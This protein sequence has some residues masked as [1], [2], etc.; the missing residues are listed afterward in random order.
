MLPLPIAP[1][2]RPA[3]PG[4]ILKEGLFSGADAPKQGQIAWRLGIARG[5]LNQLLNSEEKGVSPEMALRLERF[6]PGTR[7][8]TWLYAQADHD[9]FQIRGDRR[10]MRE[11][12]KVERW[13]GPE[14]TRVAT[15]LAQGAAE[16]G[17]SSPLRFP[18]KLAAQRIREGLASARR[19]RPAARTARSV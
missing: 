14:T 10:R 12:E 17:E 4:Q 6:F 1:T 5:T 19:S 11:I 16:Y 9:L 3:R 15:D 13:D 7:A 2:L 18:R 8:E